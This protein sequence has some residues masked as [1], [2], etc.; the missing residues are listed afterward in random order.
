[1]TWGRDEQDAIK[2]GTG[3]FNG[4]PDAPSIGFYLHGNIKNLFPYE[5]VE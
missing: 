5:R 1:M 4:L 2:A 3:G